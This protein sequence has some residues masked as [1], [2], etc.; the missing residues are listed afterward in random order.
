MSDAT[1]WWMLAGAAVALELISGTFYLLM[2][3]LGLA[4]GALAAH[5]G[6][7]ISWQLGCAALVGGGAVLAWSRQA[8]QGKGQSDSSANPD[9]NLDVGQI[10]QVEGWNDDGSTR[11]W[12][13]GAQWEAELEQATEPS[14]S[15]RYR[16]VA[17]RGSRLILAAAFKREN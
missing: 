17:V 13:R 9:L 2:L 16:I 4:A 8:R 14:A 5:A 11:V 7:G 12:H 1:L 6:A 15:G 3:A 10:V